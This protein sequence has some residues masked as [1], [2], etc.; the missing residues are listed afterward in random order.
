MNNGAPCIDVLGVDRCTGCFGCQ[1]A[2]HKG[3][4][5]LALDAEG[6]Y[7]PVVNRDVCTQC[8]LCRQR[9]PVLTYDAG[10]LPTGRWA[11]PKVYAAWALDEP[12]RLASSSGGLFS[13]LARPVIAASGAVAGC[14]WGTNW[15]PVHILT[16]TWADVEKM[17]GSKYVPSQVSD[18]YA[19]VVKYLRENSAPVLFSG[20][21]CQVAAMNLALMPEQRKRVLLVDLICHGVPSL[22]V[23]H[24]YLRKLFRGDSVASYTFRDKSLDWQTIQAVSANGKRHQVAAS[25]DQFVQGF[26]ALHLFMM[27]SCYSCSFACVPRVGDITIGDF[28]GCPE[29][30]KD[31]RGVSVALANTPAGLQ[32]LQ[33]LA[34]SGRIVLEPSDLASAVKGNPRLVTGVWAMP[35]NR[36][37]FLDGVV[38]GKS[39]RRLISK[40]FPKPAS[41]WRVWWSCF[42]SA[43]AKRVFLAHTVQRQLQK[44]GKRMLHGGP[45]R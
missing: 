7:K 45:S 4:I 38:A 5:R 18:I 34:N 37:S 17:R 35:K 29:Q 42:R 3:A 43:D 36:R 8:G 32:A 41:K 25:D 19:E 23:F 21:P 6:F 33:A 9:C 28:W 40:Y 31:K 10:R 11:E 30:W 39:F 22:R 24:I 15:T 1:T 26:C 13:E 20:T 27:A 2:C 14:V 16:R 44:L 12:L